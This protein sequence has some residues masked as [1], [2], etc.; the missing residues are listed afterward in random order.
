[1]RVRAVIALLAFLAIGCAPRLT[2]KKNTVLH[3]LSICTEYDSESAKLIGVGYD[4]ILYNYIQEY[5][6]DGHRLFKLSLC[7]DSVKSYLKIHI[8]NTALVGPGQQIAGLAVTAIGISLPITLI[9]SGL[10][11][12]FGFCYLPSNK[13]EVNYSLSADISGNDSDCCFRNVTSSPYFGSIEA[14]KNRQTESFKAFVQ[15]LLS[16]IERSKSTNGD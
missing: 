14:Q 6:H 9:A 13:S 16:E 8:S 15:S 4:S 1:M 10:P 3:D 11:F 12:Y 7:N 2:V 5:N